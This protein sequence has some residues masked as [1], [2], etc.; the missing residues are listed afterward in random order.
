[1]QHNKHCGFTLLEFLIT[2]LIAGILFALCQTNFSALLSRT[3]AKDDTYR[4]F[5]TLT[6]ARH[7]A[8]KHNQ[9]IYV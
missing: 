9:L 4:F 8:I 7:L 3:Y 1:M 2:L 6:Y 5:Q